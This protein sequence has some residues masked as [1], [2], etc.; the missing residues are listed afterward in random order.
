MTGFEPATFAPPVQR[1]TS[2]RHIPIN[3]NCLKSLESVQPCPR[4][5]KLSLLQLNHLSAGFSNLQHAL[6]SLPTFQQ[7]DL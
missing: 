2:L 3:F 6:Q 5:I 4:Y 1:A 7:L